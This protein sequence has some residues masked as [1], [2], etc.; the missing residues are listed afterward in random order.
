MKAHKITHNKEKAFKCKLCSTYVLHE[1]ALERHYAN[2]HTKDYVCKICNKVYKSKKALH[3]HE[4]V[5]CLEIIFHFMYLA[6]VQG[7][8]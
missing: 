8:L 1:E 7:Y 6:F 3:N 4:S 2:V 5:R